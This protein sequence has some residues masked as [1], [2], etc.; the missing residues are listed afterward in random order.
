MWQAHVRVEKQTLTRLPLTGAVLF[1]FKTF[2]YPVTQIKAE[3][4]GPDL[5][6]AIEGLKKGNSPASWVYK[7]AIRWGH[8]VCNYL[9]S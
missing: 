5:A 1:S 8:S 7:G 3:G 2:L 4:L 9:V 6:Q